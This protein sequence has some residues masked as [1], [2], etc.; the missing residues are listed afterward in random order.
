MLDVGVLI[1]DCPKAGDDNN[2]DEVVKLG[3][4]GEFD[5]ID[6]AEEYDGGATLGGWV[7]VLRPKD[8]ALVDAEAKELALVVAV[9]GLLVAANPEKKFELATL[10][11][12][13]KLGALVVDVAPNPSPIE[14]VPNPRVCDG[15][16]EL[17]VAVKFSVGLEDDVAELVVA[18]GAELEVAL[19]SAASNP[20]PDDDEVLAGFGAGVVLDVRL[21]ASRERPDVDVDVLVAAVKPVSSEET[22][23]IAT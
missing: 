9:A 10:L 4:D 5:D 18:D 16:E 19:A 14:V 11:E 7:C 3:I 17:L 12:G 2:D 20:V 6:N 1:F 15:P 22:T 8:V 23:K 13:P 21:L